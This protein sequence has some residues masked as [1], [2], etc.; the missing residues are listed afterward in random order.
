MISGS[1]L[2]G[3]VAFEL[4]P[5]GIAFSVGCYCTNC[6]KV[7]GAEGGVYLQVRRDGFR[8]T[9]GENEVGAYESTPGNQRGF[10]RRCGCV[11]PIVT[12][13]GAVRVPAGALDGDPGVA[14]TATLFAS[15]RAQWCD[16]GAGDISFDDTGPPEFWR[17][18]IARLY[19]PR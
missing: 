16:P 18:A 8:W 14:P 2:C 7:S 1:C 11:A 15:R 5:A 10:C 13:Y 17:E 9:A 6:R 19:A 12:N 3:A 4:D